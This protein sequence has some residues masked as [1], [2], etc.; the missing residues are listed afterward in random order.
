MIRVKNGMADITILNDSIS[1]LSLFVTIFDNL[2]P[3][4]LPCWR[5]FWITPYS[6]CHNKFWE[7]FMSHKTL[8]KC[9]LICQSKNMFFWF[10]LCVCVCVCV[11]LCFCFSPCIQSR[12]EE[13]AKKRNFCC[14]IKF[15][16]LSFLFRIKLEHCLKIKFP[17][18]ISLVMV[19]KPS[20]KCAFIHI[21]YRNPS[22]KTFFVQGNTKIGFFYKL[23]LKI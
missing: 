20:R 23:V 2:L 21:Y 1:L 6:F 15:W 22:G 19:M 16:V 10:V 14:A 8:A 12:K 13:T 17:L 11:C 7:V 3:F 18:R 9:I 4:P 5:H